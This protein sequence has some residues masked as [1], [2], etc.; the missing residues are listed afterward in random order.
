MT[1]IH[2]NEESKGAEGA[3]QRTSLFPKIQH[4]HNL[5]IRWSRCP[6]ALQPTSMTPNRTSRLANSA[7]SHQSSSLP[8]Q[9]IHLL[10]CSPP[11]SFAILCTGNFSMRHLIT[12]LHAVRIR[13]KP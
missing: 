6:T 12:A 1:H 7:T 4:T 9:K 3:I 13:K 10:P 8:P 2:A 11:A 5:T